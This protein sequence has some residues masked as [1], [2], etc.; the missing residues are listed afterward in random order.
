MFYL[1]IIATRTGPAALA[2]VDPE[3]KYE[4]KV[5][6]LGFRW[7]LGLGRV[8]AYIH[9]QTQTAMYIYICIYTYIR[10]YIHTYIHT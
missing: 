4:E 2:E 8:G 3:R 10:I 7:G 9:T 5:L 6:A 1:T